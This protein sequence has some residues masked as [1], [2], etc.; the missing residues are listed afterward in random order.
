VL[1]SIA[2]Q[3]PAYIAV[4]IMLALLVLTPWA[5]WEAEQLRVGVRQQLRAMVSGSQQRDI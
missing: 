4:A 3:D 2:I 5:L 1:A